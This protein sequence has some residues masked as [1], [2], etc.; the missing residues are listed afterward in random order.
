M[1]INLA[2]R[3]SSITTD[4]NGVAHLVWVE[5]PNLWHAV[6]NDNAQ[7]WEDAQPI[8]YVGFEP[9]ASLNLVAGPNL[10]LQSGSDNAATLP[11][12][13]VVWQQGKDNNSDFYYT[14][15]QYNS[16][17]QLQWLPGAV[18]LTSDQVGDLQP[19]AIVQDNAV[20][21]AGQKV[22]L[23][24]AANQSIQEDTDLYYQSFTVTSA[25]F[26]ILPTPTANALYSPAVI[27]NGVIQGD[28]S[29][30]P[31]SASSDNVAQASYS[32]LTASESFSIAA[33]ASSDPAF[34]GWGQNWNFSQAWSSN[35]LY[36]WGILDGIPFPGVKALLDPFFS[37]IKIEG[38]LQG[39]DGF[40]VG[41]L[42]NDKSGGLLLNVL[43][44][45]VTR[46][47]K[48]A[49]LFK[50]SGGLG[51]IYN[52]DNASPDYPLNT[53]TTVLQLTF[54]AK[55]P[56]YEIGGKSIN[57]QLDWI[58]SVGVLV[59]AVLSPVDPATYVPPLTPGLNPDGDLESLILIP[60][61]GSAAA[62][63]I[64]LGSPIAEIIGGVNDE[65]TLNSFQIGF[66]LSTGVQAQLNLTSLFQ[67]TGNG[68]ISVVVTFGDP[69]AGFTLGFPISLT[70]K[71]LG[72]INIGVGVNPS[73][74]WETNPYGDLASSATTNS[75]AL[76]SSSGEE[77]TNPTASVQGS[78]L[79]LDFSSLGTTL[80]T[81]SA[82]SGEEF[83]VTYTDGSGET[84]T[85]PVFGA[86]AQENAVILRLDNAI[87]Y[88]TLN[89]QSVT[90][91]V[92]VSYTPGSSPLEDSQGN[93][94]PGFSDL[95]VANNTSQ[96]L[97]YTYS[98]IGGNSQNY[99]NTINQVVVNFNTPLNTE[100]IPAVSNF[101]VTANDQNITV[102]S[103]LAVS[104]QSVTLAVESALTGAYT[105]TYTPG[106]SP[107]SNLQTADNSQIPAFSISISSS[108]AATTNGLVNS[109]SAGSSQTNQVI[110]NL[111]EDFAQDSPPTLALTSTGDILLAWSSDSPLLLPLSIIAD[112][113]GIIY[114]TFGQDLA[115]TQTGDTLPAADQ[116]VVTV[117]GSIFAFN[118][119]D[120]PNVSGNTVTLTLSQ[121]IS[122]TDTVTV[123]YSLAS[124]NDTDGANLNFIDPTN[125]TFWLSPFDNLA[126]TVMD[127]SSAAPA[128]LNAEF[129]GNNYNGYGAANL[130]V[131]PFDQ[132]LK[133]PKNGETSNSAFTVL[134][135]G[136]SVAVSQANV[137]S[138]SVILS[139]ET[140]S[141]NPF[142]IPQ[143]SLVSVSYDAATGGLTGS[144]GKLVNSFT[145]S[146]ILTTPPNPSTVLKTAF[147]P[148]G[149]SGISTISTIPGASGLNFDPAA[150]LYEGSNFL[151]WVNADTS[152]IPNLII[153]GEIYTDNQAEL[154]NNSL[155]AT[156][157][158]YSVLGTDNQWSVAA[159]L[160]GQ[161]AGTDGQVTLGVGPN[162]DLMAAW[163]NTQ[164]DN[165]G[166]NTTTIYYSLWQE[167][168]N[169]WSTPASILSAITPDPFT[170]LSISSLDGN[171][172]IFWT[173]TQPISY[174]ERVLE[175]DPVIY[176][177]LSDLSGTTAR[178]EGLLAGSA[179]GVYS[180]AYTL[181]QTGALQ[182]PD[183]TGLSDLGDP[184]RAALFSGG[185]VNVA[186]LPVIGQ[187]FSVEFWFKVPNL[188][189]E[190]LDLVSFG[191]LFAITLDSAIV[192][193]SL[194][195]SQASSITG[196]TSIETDAWYYVVATYNIPYQSQSGALNL[197]I[198]GELAGSLDEVTFT[199]A[200]TTGTLT[201]AGG[202]GAVYLDEVAL[203]ST[204]LTY[205]PNSVPDNPTQI[206][207]SQALE[208]FGAGNQIGDRYSAQY[209]DPV[210]PGPQ[211][212]HS[213][214]NSATSTWQSPDKINPTPL[215]TPTALADAN[216]VAWDIVANATASANGN[217][218]PNGVTDIYLPLSLPNQQAQTLTSVVV[219]ATLNGQ[220][221][222]W[223]IGAGV[224]SSTQQ[225][226]IVQGN[227]LLNSLNPDGTGFSYP[228]NTLN[229]QLNLFVDPG[230]NN[231]SDY[232]NF[233]VFINTDPNTDPDTGISVT[234][235][236]TD[237]TN[238]AGTQVLGI[239][240][241][242]ETE[243][244]SLTLIDSGF[245]IPTDNTAIGA[246]L[247]SA[248]D[249]SGNLVYTAVGN[250]GYTN[251]SGVLVEGGTVQ[252]LFAGGAVLSDNE[253]NPLTTTDLSGN[254]NGVLITGITDGGT[255]NNSAPMSLA[256]GDVD[257]DGVP[258]LVIGD[259]NANGGNG[260]IYV[261]YGSY[262]NANPGATL[263]VGD[264]T[265]TPS[266][267][268][269]V[270]NG[271]EGGGLAGFAVAVGNFDGDS[272]ADLIFGAP[273]ANGSAGSVYVLYGNTVQSGSP[274]P[275]PTLVYS[276]QTD[277]YAGY[278]LG[279]SHYTAEGP[280]TFTGSNTTDDLIIGAPGYAVTVTNQWSGQSGL[281]KENQNLYP[282]TTTVAAGAVYV[283]G[284]GSSG[285]NSF[286]AYTLT[287][288]SAPAQDGVAADSF[289]G[290]AIASGVSSMDLN[291]D[292][293]QD[294]AVSA[295]GVNNN[296]GGVYVVRGG[297]L[298]S[299]NQ[300]IE[301][302]TVA[303]LVINGGIAGSKTGFTISSPGDINDDG[304]QDFLINA[305][306]AANAAGQSYLLFGPLN[307]DSL[308]TLFDLSPTASDSKTTFLL[309]GSE[310]FQ[311]T[312]Q[313]ALGVGDIN[314]DGVDDLL[315]TSPGAQQ[316]YAVY[317]HP[318]LADD[319]SIKLADISA[320]NGFVID[321]TLYSAETGTQ[322]YTVGYESFFAP[323]L[324]NNDGVFYL[325]YVVADG[326][327]Q[328]V[329]TTSTDAGRTWS[330]GTLLPNDVLAEAG[331]ALAFY[332]GI[333]Y[334]AYM[335]AAN[336]NVANELYITYSENN[337]QTW[338]APYA[339]SQFASEGVSLA[340][341]QDQLMMFFVDDDSDEITYI[342]TNNPQSSD[343]WSTPYTLTSQG[344]AV[345][346]DG[347]LSATVMGETLFVAYGNSEGY[348]IASADSSTLDN[349]SWNFSFVTD[350]VSEAITAPGLTNGGGQLYLTYGSGLASN[351]T[352]LYYL[353]STNGSTW[354]SVNEV[355]D[356][357]SISSLSPAVLNGRLFIGYAGET[358][359]V[360]V[361]AL[362]AS[363][364]LVGTGSNVV[365]AGDLNGDGFADVLAGGNPYGA[366]VTF[367]ASTEDLL[368]AAT[369][370]DELIVS[371]ANGGLI[372]TVLA[373]G[374][375]NGDGLA[376]FGV[377][378]QDN[379]FYLVLGN[380][381][382]GPQQTL[383]LSTSANIYQ[384]NVT[385]AVAVGD[386]NGD[387]YDD[388]LL[389][390]RK[391]FKGNSSGDLNSSEAF[392]AN[393]NTVFSGIGDVNGD[394]FADIGGGDPNANQISPVST[395]PNGQGSVY[396]GNTSAS[397]SGSSSLNPPAAS[398]SAPDGLNNNAWNF[399]TSDSNQS[400]VY[401][402]SLS[403]QQIDQAPAFAVY[404]G[405]LYMAYPG[406]DSDT[407]WVQRSADGYNW[408]GLTNFGSDF[409][410]DSTF[411]LAVY[412]DTLYLAFTG[413]DDSIIVTPATADSSSALGVTFDS[414]NSANINQT[415][416]KTIAPTLAVYDN[417]LYVFFV[418][419]TKEQN[420][421][422]VTSTDGTTW[423]ALGDSTN[424]TNSAGTVQESG[425][426]LGVAVDGDNLY[427]S[428]IGNGNDDLN[429]ATYDGAAW[430]SSEISGQSSSA[431][432]SLIYVDD[433]LYNFF[434]SSNND[435]E[436]LY[437]TSTDGGDTWSSPASAVPG[438]TTNS[439][440]DPVYFQESILVGFAGAGSSQAINILTS[441]PIYEANQTQQFGAQLQPIGDF[442]GDGVADFAVLAPGFFSNLGSWNQPTSG[443]NETLLE[444][445]QGAVLIYY[446]STSG[447]NSS[448]NP[449]VVVATP[450][451]TA[452]TNAANNQALLLTQVSPA[453]D[454]NG[455][456][457]DDLVI[458]SPNTAL[459]A[460][461]TTDGVAFVV[462][463][464]GNDLWGNTNGATNPFNLGF[465][466]S[467]ISRL[468]LKFSQELLTSSIPDTSAFTVNSGLTQVAV[469]SLTVESSQVILNLNS[470]VNLSGFVSVTYTAPSSGGLEYAASGN[471]QV[472]T[473]T[474]GN[475][476]SINSTS[477]V[478]LSYDSSQVGQTQYGFQITGLPGSQ[479]GISLAG[480]G[481]VNGD[482]FSDF[483][484][485]SP[486]NN[487]N[488]TYTL[489]GSDFNN[490]VNQTGTIGDDIMV[491]TPTG[492]SFVAGQ[493]DDQIYTNG[494]LDVVY[495]GPGDDF[496][497][498]ADTY[499]RRLDGGAGTDTLA[500]AGYN[501]QNWDLTTLSP[502]LRLQNFEILLTEGY[503]SNTLALNSLTVTALSPGNTLTL[504]LD[505]TDLLV[506]SNDFSATPETVYQ[507]NRN[508]L[509]YTASG[510]AVAVLVN[511]TSSA[512]S[513]NSVS[514][515]A[516]TTNIPASI[517][518]SDTANS[519]TALVA[520]SVPAETV[521]SS[522]PTTNTE[523]SNDFSVANQP[524]APSQI[525]VSSPT[526]SE[527]LGKAEFTVSRSGDL[528][529]YLWVNYLTQDG[530]GKAGDRYTPVA[531]RAVFAPGE[532]TATVTIPI[533]NNGQYVG[534]RQF[535]LAVTLAGEETDSNLAPDAWEAAMTAVNEQIRRWTLIPG[536]DGNSV[537]F[538]VTSA[539]S[540]DR[541]V[542]LDLLLDG[543]VIP[544]IWNPTNLAYENL[545]FSNVNGVG[546]VQ[547][548]DGDLINDLYRLNFQDGGPF[549]G[550]G[551]V[552]GLVALDFKLPQLKTVDVPS[553]GGIVFGT[554]GNDYI[555]AAGQSGYY[556][557]E[558]LDGM[559][560]LVGSEQ[561]DL[562]LG[563]DGNDQLFGQGST[564]Q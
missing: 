5:G 282:A 84:K 546:Q 423:P 191:G 291:G 31:I 354:S 413:T 27:Q 330:S 401:N 105:V 230:T 161:Q 558:G 93:A 403:G 460:N 352:S 410:T 437:I 347:L 361:T 206:T 507:N 59:Q 329:L 197:Y 104:N 82:P 146:A 122:A 288:P 458:S 169:S 195:N 382:L 520:S 140:S 68:Q 549:D 44:E 418:S 466:T 313:A 123:S 514:F 70:A 465:V 472:P 141:N 440:P 237:P 150:F 157:I 539:D 251:S 562:L 276:G 109:A 253:T 216:P 422:Y 543:A 263:D 454:V 143:G 328:I 245:I 204:P 17:N 557:L 42:L 188:P 486:S 116:F 127:N 318:W 28:F 551:L 285:I 64:A 417:E 518:P 236:S 81:A 139:L 508:F 177:R 279:V 421:N 314:N 259:G 163:L 133:I 142:Y 194:A 9:V 11:G 214:W 553:A 358:E 300:E 461:N 264:L 353:T 438:Q 388:L 14:A 463:G 91:A 234:P 145:S 205:N 307:L 552:N 474:A 494:G 515:D 207:A 183:A 364:A 287:G 281:P 370:T 295:T 379:N 443:S 269:F 73:W 335:N 86:V 380:S 284:S 425:D 249:S 331:P 452:S 296:T 147:S 119:G 92:Q 315:I 498:V 345:S 502:G 273:L 400:D 346:A 62:I 453:G 406:N 459:D 39:S 526:V 505:P 210:P 219:T 397:S 305:P 46:Q 495:A 37:K 484:I 132:T 12:L 426:R 250:R 304:Y 164:T 294:L 235:S 98:P 556:R 457:Y 56:F 102:N 393:S 212:Y 342:Y 162:G 481:D 297:S 439:R 63:A 22:N 538:D 111:E 261:I 351:D 405:Y 378:D 60:P 182:N 533:P 392:T 83:T 389:S 308:A 51:T 411:S 301:I 522:A 455:D 23:D 321:G 171:P 213:I 134:V 366:I 544:L 394:G 4:A 198:N 7:I 34:Q 534:S 547:D 227:Q 136:Q 412:N 129:N 447:F 286:P 326:I 50:I 436:I 77:D 540:P 229:P 170:A 283:F 148:F 435:N 430:S 10:I 343:G 208:L 299:D 228:L 99:N 75:L 519:G 190:S 241:V 217:I 154:I 537:A 527:L 130:L 3:L 489:F 462:F 528:D 368:D 8:A 530:S 359:N 121:S 478:T 289:L 49:N 492:E 21:V 153:P 186:N 355:T 349:L 477:A 504:Y 480:A 356:Q 506:L 114:L 66:P 336:D 414:S 332:E 160:A 448:S 180:G 563:D 493:G 467:N 58:G 1:S 511:Q 267:M 445:N 532:T 38:I 117:N 482:G 362:N 385:S 106:S 501:G 446:G 402:N 369:G 232:S 2:S 302:T 555:S 386:Y 509:K 416:P 560:V 490:T 167:S 420:I 293:Q 108:S 548:L 224:N 415:S 262:L 239:A 373:A 137:N 158:Y 94:I 254:P 65:L 256:T 225:L 381:N 485:G 322:I 222:S 159:P 54:N 545:P 13:A 374:D 470:D 475:D 476:P 510:S 499:F 409:E 155:Q 78:L 317:G 372:Q 174:S 541:V 168:S 72:F 87:P 152:D 48:I 487:D 319:G 218:N 535:G 247:A 131:I 387:G 311:T 383:T 316:I 53:E 115:N 74:T 45:A 26:P 468:T 525:V 30:A 280:T 126:A 223:A 36:N 173:E 404:N 266:S 79:T 67:L 255:A 6:Y 408:E 271:L 496:V 341:Y 244:S 424:V 357:V 312:G 200:P 350:P 240:T 469:G 550:D 434:R 327:N 243:D 187:N 265:A 211:T 165:N 367:G 96:N 268:G 80:N 270:V 429:L 337:G 233:L 16:Q 491:G 41:S 450:A 333:L 559:D 464:G 298:T 442:N 274:I 88:T 272:Y 61:V 292:G 325:A 97:T 19:R 246:V 309:N 125:T 376:D 348:S 479:S 536:E 561:R 47:K 427:V 432:P 399:Y 248:F 277:D 110:A 275:N 18:P 57:F 390:Q 334:L 419:S 444:N 55:V 384:T 172:A 33:T 242:T 441:N 120:P 433:V 209:V 103:V 431:G 398:L 258:D 252:I 257:G 118:S 112:D 497:T 138:A 303:N 176:L 15:A 428:F 100:I 175:S 320:D 449:N 344:S 323:A 407:L 529:K 95:P 69:A 189:S 471:P 391:L 542:T 156:D 500:L 201:L 226:G 107:L 524:S 363:E 456:G 151:V 371:V 517:L 202:T 503:G 193:L 521:N 128:P 124:P 278:S 89:D 220:T 35:N 76:T 215:L 564:D 260:A 101:T 184:N 531:G 40:D 71:L 149:N 25:Q 365:M 360:Y 396:L 523:A 488:L 32:P 340:V 310:P 221:V 52:F 24:N 516:P 203:Y 166:E 513:A 483:V 238:G 338:S 90:N 324:I 395:I 179:N 135:N 29:S 512:F 181:N 178:N 43:G 144:E 290:A 113:Q 375:F 199:D 377:L 20:F 473:F 554:E 196:S 85:I 231:L 339:T 185:Q 306:Q 192:T 451:P